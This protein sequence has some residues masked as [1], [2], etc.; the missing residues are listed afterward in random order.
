V[1]AGVDGAGKGEVQVP[2]DHLELPGLE[3]VVQVVVLFLRPPDTITL[4]SSTVFDV[5]AEARE[6]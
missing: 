3:V 1:R 5:V 4:F 6:P 2:G